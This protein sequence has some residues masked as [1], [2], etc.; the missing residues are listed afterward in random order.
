[1]AAVRIVTSKRG[2]IIRQ[3][4]F[5]CSVTTSEVDQIAA[6]MDSIIAPDA[7]ILTVE[8]DYTGCVDE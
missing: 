7:D 1:M 8:V 3:W 2:T 4:L 6:S 5:P